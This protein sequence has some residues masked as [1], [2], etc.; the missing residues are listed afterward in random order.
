MKHRLDKNR[1]ECIAEA[2]SDLEMIFFDPEC[3]GSDTTV[4]DY[5]QSLASEFIGKY[6]DGSLVRHLQ[7][8]IAANEG[9]PKVAYR[10]L[11]WI[12]RRVAEKWS[13]SATKDQV[14]EDPVPVYGSETEGLGGYPRPPC[15][16]DPCASNYSMSEA[17]EA[18]AI[19]ARLLQEVASGRIDASTE[20]IAQLEGAIITL[21]SLDPS[22]ATE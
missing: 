1:L 7:L 6:E 4:A 13:L 18:A 14:A 11:C 19:L 20:Q 21:R 2:L 3:F 16:H 9:A 22:D 17:K 15:F 8:L 12:R 5:A 10:E